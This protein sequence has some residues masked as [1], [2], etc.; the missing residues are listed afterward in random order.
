LTREE[1]KNIYDNHF[2]GVR[3]YIYYRAGDKE[4]ATDVAQETFLKLWEKV[5]GFD[6]SNIKALLYKIAGD[7]L[8][9]N[10]RKYKVVNN[11]K[12]RII[13][14]ELGESPS[15]ILHY[16][17]LSKNYENALE[18]LPEKQRTVFLLSRMDGLKYHE[19]ADN[20]GISIKA[21]EKRMKNAL[22]YLRKAIT[23]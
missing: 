17:E 2:D 22:E 5:D 3:N 23:N 8:I 12:A 18:S 15:D 11:Y 21:V 7:I 1:F 14:E 19:I 4:L 20:I 6:A 9:T 13:S 10:L 16:K